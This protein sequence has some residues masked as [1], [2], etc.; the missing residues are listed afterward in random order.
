MSGPSQVCHLCLGMGK[1]R[2]CSVGRH[3]TDYRSGR[4]GVQRSIHLLVA[5]QSLGLSFSISK[6]GITLRTLPSLTG[7]CGRSNQTISL[8]IL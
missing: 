2:G 5:G 4:P 1:G 7:L 8:L 6:V 3:W